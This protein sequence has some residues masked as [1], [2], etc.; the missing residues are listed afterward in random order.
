MEISRFLVNSMLGFAGFVDV[1][2][3][4][5]LKTLDEDTDQTLGFYG[6]KPGPSLVLPLLQPFMVLDFAGF[7]GGSE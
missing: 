7:L 6:V 5:D 1:A 4:M 3:E 2:S